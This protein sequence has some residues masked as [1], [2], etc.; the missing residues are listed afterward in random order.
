MNDIEYHRGTPMYYGDLY[1]ELRMIEER[2]IRLR[3]AR[4]N[5]LAMIFHIGRRRPSTG[6]AGTV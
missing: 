1:L 5:R 2:G 6:V 3:E 4:R